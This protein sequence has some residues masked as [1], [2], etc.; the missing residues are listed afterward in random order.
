[1]RRFLSLAVVAAATLTPMM[2]LSSPAMAAPGP[3]DAYAHKVFLSGSPWSP[4]EDLTVSVH[5]GGTAADSGRFMLHLPHT[6]KLEPTPQCSPTDGM[7]STWSCGGAVIPAGGSR[8]YSLKITSAIAQPAFAIVAEGWVQGWSGAGA[9]GGRHNFTIAWPDRLPVKL[10][11]TAGPVTDGA[12]DV[13]VRVTNA[14]TFTLGA[15]SLNVRTPAGV[16][17]VSPGCS[18]SS[19]MNGM[20]CELY[21]ARQVKAGATDAF[22]VRLKVTKAPATVTLFLAPTN[23]Y[24]NKDTTVSLTLKGAAAKPTATPKATPTATPTAA[25]AAANGAGGG[26]AGTL[27]VTGAGTP[28]I[29]GSGVALVAVGA[30]LLLVQRRRRALA[31]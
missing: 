19:R 20:G 24:T 8:K 29:V 1:M 23:R 26:T 2:A 6:I 15:Y 10:T 11:A 4:S 21:R 3:V 28:L 5:N 7:E 18:D 17:V 31:G 27:P 30:G 16:S 13:A 25:P 14:G 22:T 9:A 12:V